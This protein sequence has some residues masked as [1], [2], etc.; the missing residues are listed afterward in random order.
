MKIN[1]GDLRRITAD[2]LGGTESLRVIVADQHEVMYD[3][4]WDHLN[5]GQGDWGMRRCR[6]CT[7]YRISTAWLVENSEHVGC[8]PLDAKEFAKHRPDLPLRPLRETG[9]KFDAT[10]YDSAQDFE[11]AARSAGVAVDELAQRVA[12]PITRLWI[13]PLGPQGGQLPREP[14]RAAHPEGFHAL[15]LLWLAHQTQAPHVREP[16]DGTGLY[17]D[18]LSRGEPSYYIGPSRDLAGHVG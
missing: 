3:A 5:D 7:Y 13:R 16:W 17:R 6:S 9:W 11:R 12:L 14:L 2:S 15:E 18:G 10:S 8:E 1:T 4:W